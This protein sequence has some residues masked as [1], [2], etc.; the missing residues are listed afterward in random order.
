MNFEE[1]I[2]AYLNAPGEDECDAL[3]QSVYILDQAQTITTSA[4]AQISSQLVHRL[5]RAPV[6]RQHVWIVSFLGGQ[7]GLEQV[8]ALPD[9]AYPEMKKDK[10]NTAFRVG[11]FKGVQYLVHTIGDSDTKIE[12]CAMLN[13][14]ELAQKDDIYHHCGGQ[15]P[16]SETAWST[17]ESTSESNVLPE[18]VELI[19][20]LVEH[21]N[22]ATGRDWRAC[23]LRSTTD[24]VLTTIEP[25]FKAALEQH[26]GNA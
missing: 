12:E 24:S 13:L 20:K 17:W 6:A 5:L 7:Y 10:L 21:R 15:M 11:G 25:F 26:E 23:L 18:W 8:I 1:R 16:V 14:D 22:A 19:R 9:D 4:H 2:C 3:F